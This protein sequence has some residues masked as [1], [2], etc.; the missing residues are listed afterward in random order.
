MCAGLKCIVALFGE[1]F[2]ERGAACEELLLLCRSC[3][4]SSGILSTR[5]KV[6]AAERLLVPRPL[7][8]LNNRWLTTGGKLGYAWDRVMLYGKGGGA[9]VGANNPNLA[10]GGF[11]QTLSGGTTNNS[12]GADQP[13]AEMS[14]IEVFHRAIRA[15]QTWGFNAHNQPGHARLFKRQFNVAK[16]LF[17][18]SR[19]EAEA[20]ARNDTDSGFSHPPAT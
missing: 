7:V 1:I 9:W 20:R 13:G 3:H 6:R 2:A 14:E 16:V 12:A 5:L 11:G 19:G 8:T 15:H 4:L 18:L 10:V 17:Y